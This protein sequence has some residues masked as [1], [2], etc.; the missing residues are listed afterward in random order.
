MEEKI[1]SYEQAIELINLELSKISSI[2][3][4]C[5]EHNLRYDT[6]LKIKNPKFEYQYP[7][8]VFNVL[9]ALGYDI[10][11]IKTTSYKIVLK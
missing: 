7:K 3:K 10:G 1:V 4:F 2:S 11:L 6:V 8:F 9:R 5:D